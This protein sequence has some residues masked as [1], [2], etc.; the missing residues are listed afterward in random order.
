MYIAGADPGKNG[1]VAILSFTGEVIETFSFSTHTDT[2]IINF[3]RQVAPALYHAYIEQI[4]IMPREK[5]GV[6]SSFKIGFAYG[7]LLW[8]FRS[9]NI[10]VEQVLPVVW[11]RELKCLSRGDKK[12]LKQ[13][14][15]DMF[16]SISSQI[17]LATADALLIAEY[18]RRIF[19]RNYLF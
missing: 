2:D 11:Q 15:Q 14:A 3:L 4:P 19:Q 10:P 16:P 5:R 9:L 6:R 12:F 8:A 18:G 7:G 17:I 13:K 1:G